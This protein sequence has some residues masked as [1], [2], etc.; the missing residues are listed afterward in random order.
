MGSKGVIIVVVLQSIQNHIRIQALVPLIE[1]E[2][3]L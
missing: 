3:E 2:H 1:H